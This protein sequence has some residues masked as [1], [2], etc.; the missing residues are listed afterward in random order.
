MF[1]VQ[2]S[3][4]IDDDEDDRRRN[5]DRKDCFVFKSKGSIN[6]SNKETKS[7]CASI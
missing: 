2:I 7:F 1:R 3:Y 4:E 6:D 5:I